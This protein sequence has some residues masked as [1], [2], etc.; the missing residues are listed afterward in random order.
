[1]RILIAGSNSTIARAIIRLLRDEGDEVFTLGRERSDDND[2]L[3]TDLSVEDNI[4]A[5][6][7]FIR[8]VNPNVIFCCSGLLH[9]E[10][11][12]PEKA[13]KQMSDA[14]LL[15]NLN[16]N[17]LCHVHLARAADGLISRRHAV[18]WISLSAMVGSIEDNHLGGWY[19]Y[20]ISK[21]ALNMFMRTLSVEWG[22]RSPDSVVVAQ[23][24]GTTVSGLSEPFTLGIPEGKI[25][26]ADQTAERLVAVM[27][28]LNETHHGRLLHWDGSV[29]PF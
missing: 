26:S 16:V 25:Y 21:A 2:H 8:T 17:L 10:D 20:R 5:I 22:R 28:S 23:H 27:R 24:P 4:P 14:W 3:C 18:R 19:S 11:G 12:Q 1:M 9:N 15:Q 13:L 7:K 6:K 29:L